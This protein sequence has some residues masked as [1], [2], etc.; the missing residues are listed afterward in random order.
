MADNCD[1]TDFSVLY[2]H[3]RPLTTSIRTSPQKY[4]GF[5]FFS[6]LPNDLNLLVDLEHFSRKFKYFQATVTRVR[7]K[8]SKANS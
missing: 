2:K 5:C 1:A 7:G 8:G 6:F 4:N 3:Q